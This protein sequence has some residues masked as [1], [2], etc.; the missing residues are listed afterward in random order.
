MFLHASTQD[1][2]NFRT[3][4]LS[5]GLSFDCPMWI[6]KSLNKATWLFI[7]TINWK[8]TNNKQI[9]INLYIKNRSHNNLLYLYILKY[10]DRTI[11]YEF[12]FIPVLFFTLFYIQNFSVF[13][14]KM[15]NCRILKNRII[16]LYLL[17]I[18]LLL[19]KGINK[20]GTVRIYKKKSAK[21]ESFPVVE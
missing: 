3:F 6:N 1:L 12:F 2:L 14:G 20:C 13:L 19:R 21:F 4:S 18:I 17:D 11:D 7:S 10:C 9:Q 8:Y 16:L 15:F 5:S